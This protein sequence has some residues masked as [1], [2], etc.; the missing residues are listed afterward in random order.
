[1]PLSRT[2]CDTARPA[3]DRAHGFAHIRPTRPHP[4]GSRPPPT[5]VSV[6]S[7][8]HAH[9]RVALSGPPRYGW[10]GRH[11]SG[12]WTAD[13]RVRRS[14]YR[15]VHRRVGRTGSRLRLALHVKTATFLPLVA[16]WDSVLDRYR[17]LSRGRRSHTVGRGSAS[18]DVG[19]DPP[20]P[21]V[22]G[23]TNETWV[24]YS[25]NRRL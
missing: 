22:S 5:S 6:D 18:G 19:G 11:V 12:R 13:T 16:P 24:G 7:P 3:C 17:L 4:T 20:H 25:R 14:P 9:G 23:G 21:F 8:R 10:N 15:P 2:R 1:L